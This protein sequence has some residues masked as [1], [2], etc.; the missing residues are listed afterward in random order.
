MF[1]NFVTNSVG[2]FSYI[3]IFALLFLSSVG[4]P[5][6]EELVLFATGYFI[7]FGLISWWPALIIALLGIVLGDVTGYWFGRTKGGQLIDW[8]RTR[9]RFFGRI[10]EKIEKFFTRHG[11]R[12]V[13]LGRFL[14]GFRFYISVVAG[15]FKMPLKQF[16]FYDTLGAIIWTPFIIFISYHVGN[17]AVV[18]LDAKKIT[19]RAYLI[20]A[21]SLAIYVM[22][23]ILSDWWLNEEGR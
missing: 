10:F 21:I 22:F 7:Y 17:L 14:V 2:Q 9:A 23:K 5:L 20:L 4:L 13:F 18:L 19:H 15:Y 12:T 1:A 6:P 16:I 8:A 11:Y 3:A